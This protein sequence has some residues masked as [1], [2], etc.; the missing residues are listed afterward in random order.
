M[1]LKKKLLLFVLL[2]SFANIQAQPGYRPMLHNGRKWQIMLATAS[3]CNYVSGHELKLY[4]DTVINGLHYYKSS[5]RTILSTV[6][7]AVC[8][9][10]YLYSI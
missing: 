5:K 6:H 7:V 2:L 1:I 3:V 9:H 4:G 8:M 10:Y